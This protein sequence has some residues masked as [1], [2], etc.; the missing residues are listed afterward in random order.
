MSKKF[1]SIQ[2]DQFQRGLGFV[3]YSESLD[4]YYDDS[5]KTYYSKG[6]RQKYSKEFFKYRTYRY[7]LTYLKCEA[8]NAAIDDI[9][10]LD[11]EK[12]IIILP[13]NN[14][15]E[16]D[17]IRI[18]GKKPVEGESNKYSKGIVPRNIN[19]EVNPSMYDCKTILVPSNRTDIIDTIIETRKENFILLDAS[20]NNKID[21]I[22]KFGL[23]INKLYT[24]V[25][26][27]RSYSITLRGSLPH[28]SRSLEAINMTLYQGDKKTRINNC[29]SFSGFKILTDV[30]ISKK[31]LPCLSV[32]GVE[33]IFE[34][35]RIKYMISDINNS[36]VSLRVIFSQLDEEDINNSKEEY[37]NPEEKLKE[38]RNNLI[39]ELEE[40]TNYDKNNYKGRSYLA[41]MIE[42]I[43]NSIK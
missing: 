5:T 40:L 16:K 34:K 10:T 20:T 28:I 39:I 12:L 4:L 7:L 36:D 13:D 15:Y 29:V 11:N 26:M 18:E 41:S 14:F 30:L 23:L 24:N 9:E 42:S 37:I 38:L 3:L 2:W 35:G 19:F 22:S 6:I 17:A 33:D 25:N 31:Y 21:C 27:N 43:S 8:I 1:Y 32:N